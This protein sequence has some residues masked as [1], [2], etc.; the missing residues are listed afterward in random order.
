VLHLTNGQEI[1]NTLVVGADGPHLMV[2]RNLLPNVEL[3]VLPIVAFNGKRIV[4]LDKFRKL[5]AP[6]MKDSKIIE[7]QRNHAILQVSLNESTVD[8][9]S[10]SWVF[11]HLARGST[12]LC[13]YRIGPTPAPPIYQMRSSMRLRSSK[14]YPNH[15][16]KYL[17]GK[18][19]ERRECCIG[20]CAQSRSKDP[21]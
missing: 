9:V 18:S 8:R 21:V 5:Y 2:R 17:I 20:S 14:I 13:M 1:D 19:C 3:I 10:I 16:P 6:R 12:T 4:S 11:S 15:T 7:M